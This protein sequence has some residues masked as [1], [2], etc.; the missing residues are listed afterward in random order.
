MF[1]MQ[2][3]IYRL[4]FLFRKYAQLIKHK[5]FRYLIRQDHSNVIK[6]IQ[7]HHNSILSCDMAGFIIQK[8]EFKKNK[9]AKC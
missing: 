5:N 1:S 2:N 8:N 9:L 3:G 4:D 6:L 7:K